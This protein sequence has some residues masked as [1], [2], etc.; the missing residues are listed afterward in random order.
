VHEAIHLTDGRSGEVNIHI[1]ESDPLYDRMAADES[2]H[3]PSSYATFAWHVTRGFDQ[4]RF[5]LGPARG[6]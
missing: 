6:Q 3:N 1:S 5:G 2:I 4:P